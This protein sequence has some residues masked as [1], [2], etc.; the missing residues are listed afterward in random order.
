MYVNTNVCSQ[1]A[2]ETMI[3]DGGYDSSDEFTVVLQPF[4]KNVELPKEVNKSTK[5]Y[6]MYL[7]RQPLKLIILTQCALNRWGK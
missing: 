6:C 2:L 3:E 1:D 7:L 5:Q 4:F